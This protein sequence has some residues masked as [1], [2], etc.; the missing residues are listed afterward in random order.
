MLQCGL[1][2]QIEHLLLRLGKLLLVAS[3]A[4]AKFL[5]CA[6]R[7]KFDNSQSR[8]FL[9][10]GIFTEGIQSA[11]PSKD[12]SIVF[13]PSNSSLEMR[14]RL[15]SQLSGHV[16][17]INLRAKGMA[18][19]PSKDPCCP[20]MSLDL[21]DR[22]CRSP[23]KLAFGTSKTNAARFD[24]HKLS[25]QN[26]VTPRVRTFRDM[27]QDLP[28]QLVPDPERAFANARSAT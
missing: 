15:S 26:Q 17:A 24:C 1:Q 20:S 9:S 2:I 11:I 23:R 27:A 25:T 19:N 12:G 5:Q 8:F 22:K 4:G 14:L 7:K 28:A 18:I 10:K 6:G 16:R 21:R 3:F 13:T